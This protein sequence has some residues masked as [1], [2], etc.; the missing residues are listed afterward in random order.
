MP[1]AV[2]Q[3]QI[4]QHKV[5]WVQSNAPYLK[6]QKSKG[7]DFMTIIYTLLNGI[8]FNIVLPIFAIII[9]IINPFIT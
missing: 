3:R 4:L 6:L 2:N 9:E 5:I 7:E 1:L 8:A